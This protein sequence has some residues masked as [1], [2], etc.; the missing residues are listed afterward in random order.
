VNQVVFSP[1][2]KMLASASTDKTIM[3]WDV[4]TRQPIASRLPVTPAACPALRSARTA[5]RSPAAARQDDHL[6]DVSNLDAPAPIGKPFGAHQDAVTA[7]RSVPMGKCLPVVARTR[8]PS[9]GM[10]LI[11]GSLPIGAAFKGMGSIVTVVFSPGGKTL[12]TGNTAGKVMLWDV[13]N[14]K[15]SEREGVRLARVFGPF[16]VWHTARWQDACHS[17]DFETMSFWDVSNPQAPVQLV[18]AINAHSRSS[19]KTVAYS[20]DGKTLA[21]GGADSKLILWNVSDPK[22][23]TPLGMPLEGQGFMNSV[24]FSPD[25]KWLAS[26][27]SST[28]I[29]RDVSGSVLQQLTP[30]PLAPTLTPVPKTLPPRSPLQI[31]APLVHTDRV[32]SVAFSPMEKSWRAASR[33]V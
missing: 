23:P 3:L 20:L 22:T 13:S 28:I 33:A 21:S 7:W 1:D 9:C 4:V 15:S 24:A 8:A 26:A 31:G 19:V 6:W 2:G 18:G 17:D 16:G 30:V 5:R 25:G 12:A 32:N 14:P 10:W 29:L 27:A 11:P